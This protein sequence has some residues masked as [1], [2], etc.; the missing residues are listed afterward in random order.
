LFLHY[1]DLS[2]ASALA[3][4]L[5]QIDPDEVYALGAQSHVRVSFDA[6]LYTADVT[7]LGALRLLEAIRESK[8]PCR[9]YQASSSEMFGAAPA[10]QNELTPFYPRSPYGVAKV[11][12]YWYAVNYREAYGLHI[13]NGILFNHESPRRG[14]TFVTKKITKGDRAHHGEKRFHDLFGEL[15]CE[16]RLGICR[17]ICGCH[18]ADG[19]AG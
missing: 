17:G 14:D 11:S 1:G 3:R 18:V 6:P 19:S 9:F 5:A 2:D 8:V 15:G 10:P 12:A 4:L 13:S 16:T 7:G